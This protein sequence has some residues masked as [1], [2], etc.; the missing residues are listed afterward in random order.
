MKLKSRNENIPGGFVWLQP[1][2][3]YEAPK[4]LSFNSVVDAVV[5]HRL[6][7]SWLAK[8]HNWS[9]DWNVVADEIEHS[10]ALRMHSNPKFSHFLSD[11]AGGSSF[12][13]PF[14]WNKPNRV[15][16]VV[17]GVKR[18]VA[19]VKVLTDWLGSSGRSVQKEQAENRAAVCVVCPQNRDGDWTTMFTKPVSDMLRL[20]LSI[21]GDLKLATSKDNQLHICQACSCPLK[22]K[23]W[24][25]LRHILDNMD[26]ETKARLQPEFPVC[27]IRSEEA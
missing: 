17:A 9:T 4:N 18:V 14:S 2:T 8:K 25:P 12:S 10:N 1:E 5:K 21:K 6:G 22:L 11:D 13:G 15:A 3:G 7:N 26:A 16:N 23:V 20:Q 27:W 19:G 24:T